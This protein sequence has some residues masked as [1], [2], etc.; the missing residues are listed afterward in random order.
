MTTEM[1]IEQFLDELKALL[2]HKNEKYND[3]LHENTGYFSK[4]D[5]MEK[6]ASRIDD[7]LNR[8]I[9]S[10]YVDANDLIDLQGYLVHLS[11]AMGIED[12]FKYY[13]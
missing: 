7:K 11:I 4:L 5:P 3:S 1:K 9:K 12:L 8:I 2:I 6:I 13:D 10:D